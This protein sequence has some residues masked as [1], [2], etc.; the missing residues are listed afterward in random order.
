MRSDLGYLLSTPLHV[1]PDSC[2][3]LVWRQI[4]YQKS[5]CMWVCLLCDLCFRR[6]RMQ[7]DM[8][9]L[10]LEYLASWVESQLVY[11]SCWTAIMSSESLKL[12]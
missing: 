2:V 7:I 4:P 9:G 3:A 6:V 8:D 11:E 1:S 5:M 10:G 12:A